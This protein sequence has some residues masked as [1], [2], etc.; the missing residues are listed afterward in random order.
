MKSFVWEKQNGQE[1]FA[2]HGRFGRPG[3]L[4]LLSGCSGDPAA[5]SPAISGASSTLEQVKLY[6]NGGSVGTPVGSS[7]PVFGTGSVTL[8]VASR[9]LTWSLCTSA[10]LADP[11]SVCMGSRLLTDTEVARVRS[12]VAAVT[13]SSASNCTP[14]AAAFTLDVKTPNGLELYA[15]DDFSSCPWS[16]QAGR[17]F[18]TGL[19]QVS[20]VMSVLTTCAAP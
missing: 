1:V 18:V 9:T 3:Q 6:S 15:S 14:D 13:P 12:A 5:A 19:T 17:S 16:L 10:S 8:D 2:W 11:A 7:C 20:D 4:Y